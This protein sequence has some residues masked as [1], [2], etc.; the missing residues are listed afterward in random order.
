MRL[1]RRCGLALAGLL[2]VGVNPT[3]ALPSG[4]PQTAFSGAPGAEAVSSAATGLAEHAAVLAWPH[5]A[6]QQNA[7]DNERLTEVVANLATGRVYILI[8]SNGIIVG[9]TGVPAEPGSLP[10]RIVQLADRKLGVLLGAVDWK[11]VD[12]GQQLASFA[13]E[14]ATLRP[15]SGAAVP[16]LNR[17]S[18]EGVAAD[19]EVMGLGVF[20]KLRGLAEMLHG[21][22]PP[23]PGQPETGQRALEIILADYVTDYGPEVWTLD[24][25]FTQVE[26]RAGSG[27]VETHVTRPRYTQLWPPEKGQPHSLMVLGYPET[28]SET[29]KAELIRAAD[30]GQSFGQDRGAIV[31]VKQAILSGDTRKLDANDA[32]TFMRAALGSS[33]G[34]NGNFAIAAIGEKTGFGWIVKQAATAGTDKPRPPGAPTLIKP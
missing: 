30:A 26:M 29:A 22:L 16:Q 20:E 32:V 18:T 10:P 25:S 11:D 5:S 6:T 7:P 23:G 13:G 24:Y 34:G 28:D 27:Y 14:V 33:G 3:V 8:T 31:M 2:A 12:S 17:E 21:P 4:F 19:I 15:L 1:A 9:A